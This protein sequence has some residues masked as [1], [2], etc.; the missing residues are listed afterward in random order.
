MSNNLKLL[1]YT[2]GMPTIEFRQIFVKKKRKKRKRHTDI[3]Q[4]SVF[5]VLA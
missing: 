5:V 2:Q 4:V 3:K 1:F